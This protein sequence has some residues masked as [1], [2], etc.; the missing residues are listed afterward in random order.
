[1]SINMLLSVAAGGAFGAVGRYLVMNGVGHWLGTGF[2][3]AT[4][5]VN[6]IGSFIL[7]AIIEIMALSWSPSP[8]IRAFVVVGVLGAFTTFSTF[9]LDTV[10][11]IERGA[12]LATVVY[13]SASVIACVVGLFAGMHLLRQ[14]L[15]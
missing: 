15:A 12:F 7:G 1:M 3:Y 9:S 6:V 8:E 2:P 14:V 5:T 11:L 4:L 13:V 10:A